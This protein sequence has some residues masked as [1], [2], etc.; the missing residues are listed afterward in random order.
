MIWPLL[1]IIWALVVG[2][3]WIS[4]AWFLAMFLAVQI[5]LAWALYRED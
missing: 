2:V 5:M 1:A 4:A 3:S